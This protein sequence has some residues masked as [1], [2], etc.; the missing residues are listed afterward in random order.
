MWES[1]ATIFTAHIIGFWSSVAYY[2][3]KPRLLASLSVKEMLPLVLFNQLVVTPAMIY[4]LIEFNGE[5]LTVESS[6]F[7]VCRAIAI[8]PVMIIIL[9]ETF[10]IAHYILHKNKW[11]YRNVHAVHHRLWIPHPIGSIYAHPIEHILGNLLPVGLAIMLTGAQWW[12]TYLLI[13]QVSYE[14]VKGHT[15][16]I[17]NKESSNH[18]LHH[19]KLTCNYDNSPYI[20]DKIMG[21]YREL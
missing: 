3:H 4:S 17:S 10:A 2:M 19:T 12:T 9:N 15:R 8:Y 11:L 7:D 1:V 6:L 21:T 5:P 14:T 13:L 16:L 18:N 20:F